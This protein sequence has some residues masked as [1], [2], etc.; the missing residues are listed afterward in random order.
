MPSSPQPFKYSKLNQSEEAALDDKVQSQQ[1][2]DSNNNYMSEFDSKKDT[3]PIPANTLSKICGFLSCLLLLICAV[4]AIAIAKVLE[5]NAFLKSEYTNY[6]SSYSFGVLAGLSIDLKEEPCC[7]F[8]TH[9]SCVCCPTTP[10][11]LETT[12]SSFITV[13]EMYVN[14]KFILYLGDIAKDPADTAEAYQ[15]FSNYVGKSQIKIPVFP[16]LGKRDQP[17]TIEN[18]TQYYEEIYRS[19]DKM[20]NC[21][22]CPLQP[23]QHNVKHTFLTGGYYEV[24]D[25]SGIRIISVNTNLFLKETPY[26]SYDI[27]VKQLAW[28]K[29]I[30]QKAADNYEPKIL[31]GGTPPGLSS[32][33][34]LN[35][36]RS[37]EVSLQWR[38][39]FQSQFIDLLYIYRH[40]FS[41]IS[42]GDGQYDLLRKLKYDFAFLT[43]PCSPY[44]CTNPAFRVAFLSERD[45]RLLDFHQYYSPIDFFTR[46]NRTP[47]YIFDHS[48]ER[49]VFG[50][51][52]SGPAYLN[53]YSLSMLLDRILRPAD[54]MW[55]GVVST[56]N[57]HRGAKRTSAYTI[58]CTSQYAE[59]SEI[60]ECLRKYKFLSSQS[61]SDIDE[62]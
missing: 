15:F 35:S 3:A 57:V 59:R 51:D 48:T 11:L 39:E 46:T 45:L 1:I 34:I 26:D 27:A 41:A 44:H 50:N 7:K 23:R 56:L 10:A 61:S 17:K 33:E 54:Y 36:P 4:L 9:Y 2:E 38:E 29:E 12:F 30:L 60:E 43:P 5:S 8:D 20:I 28:L 31:I 21:Y 49:I 25:S 16:T 53:S 32:Q 47:R 18:S 19:W 22:G 40:R 13:L 62:N 14:T 58:M 6:T 52:V 24:V 42:M 37:S 55:Q